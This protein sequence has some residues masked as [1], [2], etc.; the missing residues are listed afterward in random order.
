MLTIRKT[1]ASSVSVVRHF[2]IKNRELC[3]AFAHAPMAALNHEKTRNG[4][5]YS[6]KLETGDYLEQSRQG[7]SDPIKHGS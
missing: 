2:P 5:I 3:R 4:L 1:T 7:S 6:W